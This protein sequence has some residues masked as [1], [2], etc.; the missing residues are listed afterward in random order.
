MTSLG[1][2]GV[3]W[4]AVAVAGTCAVLLHHLGRH[5]HRLP[6]FAH[7]ILHRLIIAGMH[8][9]GCAIALTPLG[10]WVL[11]PA[12]GILGLPSGSAHGASIAAV[13]IAGVFLFLTVVI[14]LIWVPAAEVA[15]FAL[16]LPF[17]AAL[18]SG[19]HLHSL[20]TVF[21]VIHWCQQIAAWIG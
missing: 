5:G 10:G 9:A 4:A 14:G 11:T 16:A 18:S 13:I 20:L 19:G 1:G 2:W 6:G 15:W 8:V 3:S 21:P 12:R 17:V 7:P